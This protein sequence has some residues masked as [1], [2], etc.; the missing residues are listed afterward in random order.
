MKSVS[1][2]T[3]LQF[4]VAVVFLKIEHGLNTL[5][6]WQLFLYLLC[7]QNSLLKT[8]DTCHTS[9]VNF[10]PIFPPPDFLRLPVLSQ[11]FI[12]VINRKQSVYCE[13]ERCCVLVLNPGWF[14]PCMVGAWQ[15]EHHSTFAVTF[16]YVV[17]SVIIRS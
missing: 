14:Y 8:F 2:N 10:L 15:N 6:L 16:N 17:L 4:N 12:K 3:S 7:I 1:K 11:S 13:Q 5:H 9:L